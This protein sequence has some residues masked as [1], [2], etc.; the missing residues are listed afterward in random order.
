MLTLLLI[1]ALCVLACFL[2]PF[3]IA[4]ALE[5]VP[6]FVGLLVCWWLCHLVGCL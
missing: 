2:L 4:C 6:L 3:V 5:A 1:I